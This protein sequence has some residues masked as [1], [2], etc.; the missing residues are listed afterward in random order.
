MFVSIPPM[1]GKFVD[2][3]AGEKKGVVFIGKDASDFNAN[4]M[5]V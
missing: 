5:G 3:E 4:K 1:K 2:R